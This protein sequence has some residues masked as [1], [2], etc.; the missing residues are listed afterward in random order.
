MLQVG[1]GTASYHVTLGRSQEPRALSWLGS[2]R[3]PSSTPVPFCAWD[4]RAADVVAT[5]LKAYYVPFHQ[6]VFK[7]HNSTTR[8]VLLPA[9]QHLIQGP[10]E[11]RVSTV[12]WASYK[13]C[14]INARPEAR[15]SKT[16]GLP[17]AQE[18]GPGPGTSRGEHGATR[19]PLVTV[20]LQ[21][22]ARPS[23]A[24]SWPRPLHLQLF[25]SRGWGRWRWL[26]FR[27]SPGMLPSR[28]LTSPLPVA[29]RLT[30]VHAQEKSL[31]TGKCCVCEMGRLTVSQPPC[32][33][34][35]VP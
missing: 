5:R 21:S 25:L 14:R 28:P 35:N 22:R 2:E 8:S 23:P 4:E 29:T 34:G 11:E 13:F 33:L 19:S 12:S 6:P 16:A 31:E 20:A 7:H 27:A 3:V 17:P 26:W 10:R 1:S 18:W 24:Q 15:G 32:I 30:R 9:S